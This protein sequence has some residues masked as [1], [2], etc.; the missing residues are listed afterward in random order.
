[1]LDE[2]PAS[3][4]RAAKLLGVPTRDMKVVRDALHELVESR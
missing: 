2:G 4:E 1:L 3:D